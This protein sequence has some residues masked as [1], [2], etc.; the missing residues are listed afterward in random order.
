MSDDTKTNGIKDLM[1]KAG[2]STAD[3]PKSTYNLGYPKPTRDIDQMVDKLIFDYLVHMTTIC[4]WHKSIKK[5]YGNLPKPDNFNEIITKDKSDYDQKEM[6]EWL[7]QVF[8]T[9]EIVDRDN[10]I[11]DQMPKH[12]KIKY[13]A[14]VH[15]LIEIISTFVQWGLT[16]EDVLNLNWSD[17]PEEYTRFQV[18]QDDYSHVLH[19]G[20]EYFFNGGSQRNIVK[21]LHEQTQQNKT[22]KAGVLL[23]M[24]VGTTCEKLRDLFDNGK[25]PAF[26]NL[27][28]QEPEGSG[29]WKLNI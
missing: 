23:G 25:H 7:H 12:L 27:I 16:F 9:Q 2:V 20:V 17:C 19:C 10:K 3:N 11:L 15:R 24:V 1:A 29:N 8:N 26:N 6:T 28:I 13:R 14:T 21:Y 5:K 22:T 18:L 4:E